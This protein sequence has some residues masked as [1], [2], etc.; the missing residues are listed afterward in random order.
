MADVDIKC[1][2]CGRVVTISEFA[3]PDT[4]VCSECGQKLQKPQ[5]L[6]MDDEA[7]IPKLRLRDPQ[8]KSSDDE[9]GQV[10]LNPLEEA[11]LHPHKV[12][13][14]PS[15]ALV[16]WLLFLL[17]GTGM[18]YLRYGNVLSGH[19]L[20]LLKEYGPYSV[21]A[22]H[23]YIIL[24]AMKDSLLQGTLC[25]FVPFYSLFYVFSVADNFYARAVIAAILVG[26]GLD[27]SVFYQEHLTRAITVVRLWI[28]SGG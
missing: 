18:W 12:K 3:S 28:A 2:G 21:I 7:A 25:L 1:T 10:K 22:I 13:S 26:V 19:V 14:R 4:L 5:T 9:S 27:S 15:S 20:S 6:A 11:R 16:S 17:L 24:L 8:D 23:A